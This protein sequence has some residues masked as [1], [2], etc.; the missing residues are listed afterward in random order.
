ML[1]FRF[2]CLS[3]LQVLSI[4][5]LQER[6]RR[7]ILLNEIILSAAMIVLTADALKLFPLS[8][9]DWWQENNYYQASYEAQA[10]T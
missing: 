1:M 9:T 10:S 2:C 7:A 8:G 5:E 3:Q 6:E 4:K